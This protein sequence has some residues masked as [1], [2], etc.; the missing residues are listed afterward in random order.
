M[1][2]GKHKKRINYT[3]M[4]VSDSPEGGIRPFCLEKN[5]VTALLAVIVIALVVSTGAAFYHSDASKKVQ[6][7]ETE[8]QKKVDALTEENKQLT[9]DNAELADKVA[10]LSDT[11]AQNEEAK[12]AQKKEE[13]A[14][15]IPNG[16]PL[17]GPAVILESSE[18]PAAQEAAE[19]AEEEQ[20][21]E[22]PAET[23]PIVVFSAAPDTR[24]IATASGIVAS[25]EDDVRYGHKVTVN[26][27][28]GYLS[29]YRTSSDVLVAEGDHVEAGT[30]L[31]TIQSQE[32]KLGYQISR[33]GALID[34]LELLEVYG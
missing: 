31:Y 8:L 34:P 1:E 23:D 4:V 24:V 9:A 17:A 15:L 21:Q 19:D 30:P 32:Q 7:R 13:E 6:V 27:G 18:T 10:L 25:V 5:L 29:I 2:S 11:V 33:D 22:L 14:K 28:N 26:H 16:F 12:E 3:V 20:E